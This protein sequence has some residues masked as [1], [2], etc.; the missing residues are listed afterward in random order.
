MILNLLLIITDFSVCYITLQKNKSNNNLPNLIF[1]GYRRN[2]PSL[3]HQ[4][5][6]GTKQIDTNSFV[7][8]GRYSIV[9]CGKS[10]EYHCRCK[11]DQPCRC[12]NQDKLCPCVKV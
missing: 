7:P 3:R 9:G 4:P 2:T 6:I 11:F 8:Y 5:T 12:H 1:K 10:C